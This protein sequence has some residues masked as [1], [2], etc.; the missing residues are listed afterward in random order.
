MRRAHVARAAPASADARRPRR[1]A[2]TPARRASPS[3]RSIAALHA[4]AAGRASRAAPGGPSAGSRVRSRS[5][6]SASESTRNGMSSVTTSTTVYG[7]AQ[8]SLATARVEYAHQRLARLRRAAPNPRWSGGGCGEVLPASRGAQV[9]LV[10]AAVVDLHEVRG[11]T[12]S[13]L[14]AACARAWRCRRSGAASSRDRAWHGGA[15]LGAAVV[16]DVDYRSDR[17]AAGPGRQRVMRSRAESRRRAACGLRS[18]LAQVCGRGR[19]ALV[20]LPS[21]S[22]PAPRSRGCQASSSARS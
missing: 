19:R 22:S 11:Q 7:D 21:R 2:R 3:R 15:V 6:P 1:A 16:A 12:G 18:A 17:G 9:V 20:S 14:R 4:A 10:D 13:G 8:P 5:A